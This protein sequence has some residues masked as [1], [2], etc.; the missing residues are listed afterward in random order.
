MKWLKFKLWRRWLRRLALVAPALV[1]SGCH[2]C[3][4]CGHLGG[5]GHLGGSHRLSGEYLNRGPT[6]INKCATITAGSMPLEPGGHVQRFINIQAEK[7][8]QDDFTIHP[9]EWYQ[10]GKE[11]G[12]YGRYHIDQIARRW[13][14]MPFQV[15]IATSDSPEI[16]LI[17]RD[18]VLKEL[19]RRGIEDAEVRV[20]LGRP[21]AEG[22]FGDE[23]EAIYARMIFGQQYGLF[24]NP[25]QGFGGGFGGGGF[26]GFGGFGGLGGTFGGFGVY[27][28]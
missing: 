2:N 7:A 11:L 23:M 16:D 18:V 5:G 19:G 6:V 25:Y 21:R 10:G 17:R 13:A 8:E 4:G 14:A 22:L 28:R 26:G 9:N 1:L 3:G 20:V 12:P 15:I 24:G 27:G